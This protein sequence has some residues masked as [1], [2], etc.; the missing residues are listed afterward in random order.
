MATKAA[1]ALG[2]IAKAVAFGRHAVKATLD[3]LRAARAWIKESPPYQ[4]LDQHVIDAPPVKATTF[5]GYVLSLT[6]ALFILFVVGVHIVSSNVRQDAARRV[7]NLTTENARLKADNVDLIK[8]YMAEGALTQASLNECR[9]M[10]TAPKAETTIPK[11]K[12]R[13]ASSP[14]NPVNGG[15]RGPKPW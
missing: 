4:W 7:K 11:S 9:A 15:Y 13:A 1:Q 8:H 6:I 10:L 3:K 5:I 2:Y 12:R 14:P